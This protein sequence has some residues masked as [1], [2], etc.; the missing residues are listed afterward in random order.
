M[1]EID[2]LGNVGQSG[3][4]G[5][6]DR[7]IGAGAAVK[8]QQHR[9]FPHR[10]AVGDELRTLDVEEQPHPVHGHMHGLASFS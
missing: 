2:D 9:L 6:V 7:V 5:P 10:R 1:V 4:G 3:V 8:H